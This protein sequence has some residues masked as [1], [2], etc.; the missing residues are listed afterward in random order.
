MNFEIF[1]RKSNL[2]EKYCYCSEFDKKNTDGEEESQLYEKRIL[3]LEG[4]IETNKKISENEKKLLEIVFFFFFF[5]FNFPFHFFFEN[6]KIK[7]IHF[8]F[9]IFVINFFCFVS[10]LFLKYFLVK[11]HIGF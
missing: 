2:Q 10:H 9:F 7:K 5:I 8:H 6:K 3:E 4:K 1:E 11:R